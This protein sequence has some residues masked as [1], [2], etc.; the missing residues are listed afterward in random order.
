M[1]DSFLIMLL[2]TIMATVMTTA[3]AAE[4]TWESRSS[5]DTSPNGALGR[6]HPI[7]FANETHGFVIG[8][9]TMTVGAVNDLY[10]YD[11]QSDIW[12]D[13]SSALTGQD[14]P[15]RTYSYGVVLDEV[16]HPKAYMRFGS[17]VLG[18]RLADWWELD[19]T[20]LQFR[21]LATFPGAG[22]HHPSMVAVYSDDDEVG[23]WEIHVGLGDGLVGN[24]MEFSNF[25]D[26]WSY[27]V[28]T[29][30]WTQLP[31]FPSSQRHHPYYFGIN[32]VSYTGFGH[33]NSKIERDF[34][35]FHEGTWTQEP[36]FESYSM[37]DENNLVTTEGRVAGTQ[38]SI[39]LPMRGS[40][41]DGKSELSGAI[42]FVLS[43]DGDDHR[44]MYE[45]EFH[46]FYP[47][48]AKKWRTLPP[49]P[50]ES[51]WAPGSFVMRGTARVY[52]TSGYEH[53]T[54][55][56]YSD[57]WAIDLSPLFRTTDSSPAMTDV[58]PTDSTSSSPTVPVSQTTDMMSDGD[59][60]G[61]SEA[62]ITTMPTRY[63]AVIY[64]V[65]I[66]VVF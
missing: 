35:S 46:A 32:G 11:E 19:M 65:S 4:L 27:S 13:A 43:G 23:G 16:N 29:D 12:T 1:V 42:G 62:L 15:A 53:S 37:E 24:L 40:T 56:L 49:H 30:Q 58:S 44:T 9:S 64:F 39:V 2:T 33:S 26:Y 47:T 54:G 28:N 14:F 63:V 51:R 60:E 18:N 10:I 41:D 25:D 7:T 59:V 8:G 50:G 61:S 20:T 3:L 38:F 55:K 52:F 57:V 31:N 66:L 6:H 5:Y 17:D 45:G 22:R 21:Q 36:D 34:Y 48:A